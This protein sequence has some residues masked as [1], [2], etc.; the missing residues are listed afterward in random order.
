LAFFQQSRKASTSGSALVSGSG[1]VMRNDG[2]GLS[3]SQTTSP[4]KSRV[5]MGASQIASPATSPSKKVQPKPR[6][7]SI[8]DSIF[9]VDISYQSSKG[10]S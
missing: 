3:A 8:W 7:G 10:R 2:L 4:S 9:Q 1:I 6:S 5:G